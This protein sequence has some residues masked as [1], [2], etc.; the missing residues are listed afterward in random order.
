MSK[1]KNMR[2][3]IYIVV[4]KATERMLHLS[5]QD[6]ASNSYTKVL[7]CSHF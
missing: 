5:V 2:L 3:S 7:G 4:L 6:I 1:K